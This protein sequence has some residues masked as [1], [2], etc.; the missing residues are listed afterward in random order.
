[1]QVKFYAELH[2]HVKPKEDR[3]KGKNRT[4]LGKEV[5]DLSALEFE[6]AAIAAAPED[7][8]KKKEGSISELHEGDLRLRWRRQVALGSLILSSLKAIYMR[9]ALSQHEQ[10][11]KLLIHP[12]L[13]DSTCVGCRNFL[14]KKDCYRG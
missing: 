13:H 4:A 6:D 9:G 12:C 1:M 5:A 7:S 3:K 2:G 14:P 11:C 10:N 8:D